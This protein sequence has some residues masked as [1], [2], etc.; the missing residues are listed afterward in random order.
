MERHPGGA[1][2][3]R[4]LVPVKPAR[5]I[6]VKNCNYLPNVM[7]KREAV[8]WGV[9]FVVGFDDNGFM[10]EGAAENVGIV[11]QAGELLFPCMGSVLDGTTM[12]RVMHLAEAL[13]ASGDLKRVAFR[14]IT[15]QSV[16][17]AAEMLIVGTTINVVSVN[18]FEGA[19][20]GDGKP[21]P[22][23]CALND[24]L[25]RDISTNDEIRTS[26]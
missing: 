20:V 7:M 26:Y 16:R 6:T 19:P 11:T 15:E 9:D 14:D 17:Q 1:R 21:G 12:L 13:L 3:R 24:L 18:E 8:N 22:V 2:V 10:A 23:G 25:A 4:S 5:F